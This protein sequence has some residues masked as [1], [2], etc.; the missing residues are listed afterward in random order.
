MSWPTSIATD[1]DLYLAV[2]NLST[3]LTDNPLT[4]GATTVN[5]SD[6]SSFPTVGIITIDLEA[7][8]YTG[9]T[10]TSF[11][12]CT[13]GFD[14]TT[15]AS[16]A[17]SATVFHDIPA[18][19]HNVLK[20]EIIA[21]ET[22][23]KDVL[24]E[25]ALGTAALP[26]YS[27]I[28]RTDLGIFSPGADVLGFAVEGRE[29]L[30]LATGASLRQMTYGQT[31]LSGGEYRL[32]VVN[33]SDTAG[34]FASLSAQVSGPNAGDPYLLLDIG[35]PTR[36][37]SFGP[38]NSD[39]DILKIDNA[40]SASQ[41]GTNT[42]L[43]ITVAGEMTRPL[44]PSFLATQ[45]ATSSNVTG[46][47]TV[48]T[49]S[50]ATEVYDQNA[51]YDGTDTFTA[52]VTGRYHFD[53]GVTLSGFDGSQTSYQIA[54]VSSN[55]TV[56]KFIGR[57]PASGETIDTHISVDLDMDASDTCQVK[58]LAAGGTLVVDTGGDVERNYFS[59]SLIN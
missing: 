42:S 24:D 37:W 35:G 11:T 1:A 9:T 57:T 15:G 3:V 21:L 13:R 34:T 10:A 45:S 19:H 39:A 23:L 44:Q 53:A 56:R 7:I 36:S 48:H 33:D 43:A 2:N 22:Y 17:L 18:A 49:Q 28:G 59:G 4:A 55:R 31:A 20:D 27:F 30:R 52:P 46:D 12:G 58:V 8:H 50:F 47:A 25:T 14:G 16:H 51:D 41:P 26:S 54:L 32:R 38:D 40:A 5:V 29:D 6:A